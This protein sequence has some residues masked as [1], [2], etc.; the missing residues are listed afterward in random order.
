MQAA[1]VPRAEDQS[2][3]GARWR[4]VFV[5]NDVLVVAH[6]HSFENRRHGFRFSLQCFCPSQR[7]PGQAE[8][9]DGVHRERDDEAS[10]RLH[11]ASSQ[12]GTPMLRPSAN[13][14]ANTEATSRVG[15]ARTKIAADRVPVVRDSRR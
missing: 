9:R 12:S 14:P 6:T 3:I 10:W 11:I 8:Q 13:R 7:D 2:V 5:S 4:R 1:P 15:S